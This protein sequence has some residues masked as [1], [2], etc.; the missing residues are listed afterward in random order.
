MWPS[1]ANG[2]EFF[3]AGKAE[4]AVREPVGMR[5]GGA[6]KVDESAC[7]P[8]PVIGRRI[9]EVGFGERARHF[10]TRATGDFGVLP[11][12]QSALLHPR[13]QGVDE[14]GLHADDEMRIATAD[15]LLGPQPI[16]RVR[17]G[18]EAEAQ[19]GLQRAQ[20]KL[21]LLAAGLVLLPAA[22]RV[23]RGLPP[24]AAAGLRELPREPLREDV[25]LRVDLAGFAALRPRV[26]HPRRT[27]D[28][29]GG[30]TVGGLGELLRELFAFEPVVGV[31]KLH[32][33]AARRFQRL[34]PRVISAAMI[35]ADEADGVA[36]VFQSR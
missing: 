13:L 11:F 30:G 36:K 17:R 20:V 15:G 24:E 9:G 25:Q 10:K 2:G 3:R 31:E 4:Q 6:G 28:H 5:G 29:V 27:V 19:P 8:L 12:P 21:V 22:E 14:R 7:G 23:E 16:D 33:L 18:G 35:G 1:A 26:F 34:I 32:P